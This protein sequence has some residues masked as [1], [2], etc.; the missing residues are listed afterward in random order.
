VSLV[1]LGHFWVLFFP[2][3]T[4]SSVAR[5]SVNSPFWEMT[6]KPIDAKAALQFPALVL[7]AF[8]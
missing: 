1:V 5:F 2:K 7:P 6:A 4:S 8:N 3:A